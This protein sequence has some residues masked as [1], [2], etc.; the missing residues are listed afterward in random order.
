[1]QHSDHCYASVF[2]ESLKEAKQYT[3]LNEHVHANDKESMP[4]IFD[5]EAKPGEVMLWFA[6]GKI[7]AHKPETK[8]EHIIRMRDKQREQWEGKLPLE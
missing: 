1:M 8:K 4:W 3:Q 5:Q 2:F 6:N 7:K